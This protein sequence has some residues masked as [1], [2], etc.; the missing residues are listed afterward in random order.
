MP[1]RRQRAMA[2]LH[3]L[4]TEV[5]KERKAGKNN[6]LEKEKTVTG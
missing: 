5:G 1:T 6:I 3:M 2:T 4:K